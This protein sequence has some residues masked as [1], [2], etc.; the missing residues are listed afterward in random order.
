MGVKSFQKTQ[1]INEMVENRNLIEYV[2]EKTGLPYI[3]DLTFTK[4]WISIVKD[5]INNKE[6]NNFSLEEW[7]E[8]FLY[9]NS[10]VLEDD[11][12]EL[13]FQIR[14]YIV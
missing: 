12:K 2:Y 7:E 6:V 3:S 1:Q 4:H 14:N 9:V 13:L 11:T 10:R 5:I 8:F